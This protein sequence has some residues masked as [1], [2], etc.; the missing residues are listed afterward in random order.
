MTQKG[1][2]LGTVGKPLPG[3]VARAIDPTTR[4][5]LGTNQEGLIEI[6]GPNIMLGYWNRPDKTAAVLK[7]GWYDTGDM[8]LV[9][10][11][12]FLHITGRISRFSK[13]GGEMVPHLKIEECLLKIM[14]DPANAD[15]GIPLAVTAIPD[16]K[17]G[18]R[19]IVLHRSLSKPVSQIIDELSKCDL[20]NLFIPSQD[21]FIEVTEIPV[22]GTGKLDLRAVKQLA[23]DRA[24]V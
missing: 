19:L 16:S 3:V 1:T 22:L 24:K 23:L 14:D 4:Q 20:P 17:K 21:S 13:I 7:D 11:E 8:G 18:E 2:K 5:P 10:G 9:D 6:K 12:G 15:A